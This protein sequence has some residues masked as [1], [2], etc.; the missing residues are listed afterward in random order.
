M[1]MRMKTKKSPL[2]CLVTVCVFVCWTY[3]P[4][5]LALCQT[6]SIVLCLQQSTLPLTILPFIVVFVI[7]AVPLASIRLH[8]TPPLFRLILLLRSSMVFF[9]Y[10]SVDAFLVGQQFVRNLRLNKQQFTCRFRFY[11]YQ[12]VYSIFSGTVKS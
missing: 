12:N 6:R 5:L 3:V 8:N 10:K 9:S 4:M 7:V 2:I 11:L 1:K